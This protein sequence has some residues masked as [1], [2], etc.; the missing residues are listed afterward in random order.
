MAEKTVPPF[1]LNY[2]LAAVIP[3]QNYTGVRNRICFA[4]G[5]KKTRCIQA[6]SSAAKSVV[7][8][9]DSCFFS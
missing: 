5:H 9:K 8:C 3:L 6:D 7:Q 4:A 1:P 2:T